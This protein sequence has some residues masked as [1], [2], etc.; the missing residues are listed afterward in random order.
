[1]MTRRWELEPACPPTHLARF[2][3]FS[4]LLAQIL[5]NRGITDPAEARSF[6]YGDGAGEDPLLML[7]MGAAVGRLRDAI[8]DGEPI[9]VYGDFDADGVTATALLVQALKSLGAQAQPYIPRRVEEGYG[10]NREAL[11]ALKDKGASVVVT[12]DCGIRSLQEVD[13]AASLGLEMIVTDHHSVGSEVPRARA[14]VNPKQKADVYPFKEFSGAGLAFKLAQAL[15]RAELESPLGKGS[16]LQEEELLDLVALGTV[17]DLVPLVSENRSLVKRGLVKLNKTERPGLVSLMRRAGAR[18]RKIDAGTIGYFLGPRLNAAG[19][20]EHAQLAY[21]LLTVQYPGE[22]DYLADK[23]E[24]LNRDRQQKTESMV[25]RAR[26]MLSGQEQDQLILIAAATEF[27]EGII[28]LVASKLSEDAYRPAIAIHL[29]DQQSRGSARSIPEFN[30][31][32]AFDECADLL[33]RHGGHAA[34]AGFTVENDKL[35]ALEQRLRAIAERQLGGHEL[36]PTLR[37]DALTKLGE[38]NWETLKTLNL[39]A[40]C[41]CGNN[42]PVFMTRG[43]LVRGARV[44]GNDHLGLTFTDGTVVWDG[45]A[46]RGKE[47]APMLGQLPMKVDVI[48]TL[49]SRDWSGEPRLQLEVKDLRLPE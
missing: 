28:G 10:L 5:Y 40:P 44:I 3:Q 32:E 49:S 29:G 47:W 26:D 36:V 35:E 22:A 37:V 45:I 48:Y 24:N 6:L 31:V 12:V 43:A 23:L 42:E 33:V 4:P 46:F 34:A 15:F 39:V 20:I 25:S 30:I 1:M 17:A 11:A 14:V 21:D 9:A 38:M 13:Y 2:S 27:T 19:R 7:G 8:R 16:P 18:N 41:G